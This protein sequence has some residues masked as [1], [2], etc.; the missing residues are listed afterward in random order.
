MES[1]GTVEKK[2]VKRIQE[3]CNKINNVMGCLIKL[4]LIFE[5]FFKTQRNAKPSI[6][7]IMGSVGKS[8]PKD[9]SSNS[10]ETGIKKNNKQ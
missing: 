7:H 3:I 6:S 10:V 9:P 2:Q 8:V 1:K 4:V 5:W